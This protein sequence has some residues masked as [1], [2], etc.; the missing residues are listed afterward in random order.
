MN[1]KSGD[2]LFDRG[3]DM[4]L[5]SMDLEDTAYKKWKMELE[6]KLD[7]TH[8]KNESK[9]LSQ[10]N[11]S[12]REVE[13]NDLSSSGA[14]GASKDRSKNPTSSRS[15]SKENT[16]LSSSSGSFNLSLTTASQLVGSNFASKVSG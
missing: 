10:K 16:K 6:K 2:M 8:K 13:A 4:M 15:S 14:G 7:S 3:D 11:A 5:E 12:T 1:N 9:N